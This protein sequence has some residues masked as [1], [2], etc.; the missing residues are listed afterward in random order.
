MGAFAMGMETED[1]NRAFHHFFVKSCPNSN[2]HFWP[3]NGSTFVF[4]QCWILV[5]WSF[6]K[7]NSSAEH[8]QSAIPQ[9]PITKGIPENNLFVKAF[10]G[11]VPKVCWNN[12]RMFENSPPTLEVTKQGKSQPYK[13]RVPCEVR[14][15]DV[16]I[17]WVDVPYQQLTS[18]LK[19]NGWKMKCPWKGQLLVSESVYQDRLKPLA[20]IYSQEKS[21]QL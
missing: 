12:L 2:W 7:T 16:T 20:K 10:L 19:I 1:W 18:T 11:C 17:I 6:L 3:T 13:G 4:L 14:S 21:F 8:T 15:R 5:S 9:S